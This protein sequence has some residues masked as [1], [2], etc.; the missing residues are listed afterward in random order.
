MIR[1]LGSSLI[2]FGFV[3]PDSGADVIHCWTER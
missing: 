3:L 2:F 1:L